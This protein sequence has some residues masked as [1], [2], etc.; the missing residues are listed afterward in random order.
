MIGS[1][2]AARGDAWEANYTYQIN[3][4]LSLQARYVSIDYDYAGSNGF[5]GNLSGT[6][7]KIDDVKAAAGA[8]E[9]MGGT[10]DADGAHNLG[11]VTGALMAQGMPQAQAQATAGA[12]AGAALFAPQIV[13]KAQ[14]FRLYL[15]YRF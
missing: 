15:R 3:D 14:D 1:K 7:M 4:A 2:V 6:S 12:M 8:F 13:E 10:V 11:V 9:Q 5:F